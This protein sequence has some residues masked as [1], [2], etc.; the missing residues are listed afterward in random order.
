[1]KLSQTPLDPAYELLVTLYCS[2]SGCLARCPLSMWRSCLA[3]M[4]GGQTSFAQ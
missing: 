1:L 3:M 4:L 2:D